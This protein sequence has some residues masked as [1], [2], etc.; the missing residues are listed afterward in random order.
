[1]A[2]KKHSFTNTR[3]WI[4]MT[5][6]TEKEVYDKHGLYCTG[7]EEFE[8]HGIPFQY[9]IALKT[10]NLDDAIKIKEK[11]DHIENCDK[12]KSFIWNHYTLGGKG[13]KE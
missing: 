11:F 10:T 2:G 3:A 1:M 9:T 13:E 4:D 12:C 6:I 5:Y 8:K 7:I